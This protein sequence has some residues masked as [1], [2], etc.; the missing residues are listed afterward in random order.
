MSIFQF[1]FILFSTFT[2]LF[3]YLSHFTVVTDDRPIMLD[4]VATARKE[5]WDL[6]TRHLG[7]QTVSQATSPNIWK[8][9]HYRSPGLVLITCLLNPGI[10]IKR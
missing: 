2:Y 4:Q 8:L 5:M 9:R 10:I 1:F 6:T 3:F 7:K